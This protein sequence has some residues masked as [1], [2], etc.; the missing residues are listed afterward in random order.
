[1]RELPLLWLF[2]KILEFGVTIFKKKLIKP[3]G[4]GNVEVKIEEVRD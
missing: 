4:E 3:K 2:L 1:M